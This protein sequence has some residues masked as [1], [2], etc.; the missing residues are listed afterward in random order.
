MKL[1]DVLAVG[2][3]NVDMTLKVERL[4]K[5]DDKVLGVKIAEQVGGTVANSACVCGSLGLKTATLARVADDKYGIKVLDEYVKYN[6][7]L[8]FVFQPK[9]YEQSTAIIMLDDSGEKSLIFVPSSNYE[10]NEELVVVAVANSR[11]LY[12]MPG[13]LEKFKVLAEIAKNNATKV[14]VD[15][16]PTIVNEDGDLDIILTGA[17]LVYFN[18]EGFKKA[19]GLG[20]SKD[21]LVSM[22]ESY[23]LDGVVVTLGKDGVIAFVNG[24]FGSYLGFN[25]PVV[26]TT[27]AGDTFNASF[28]YTQIN[29]M[30]LLSG[31]E[32]AC[33]A[34][35]ISVSSVGPKGNVP[36][37]EKVAEFLTLNR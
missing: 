35:A 29:K 23:Q 30:P 31:L 3:A 13:N 24:E 34:A 17:D 15:I 26:D 28:L 32:F 25:V 37:L 2:D 9:G 33:A 14:V 20:P 4:P 18:K 12:T 27:G 22:V 6:V 7:D 19:T 36:T 1:Y 11:Y 21:A 8:K 5:Q 10:F 16:E